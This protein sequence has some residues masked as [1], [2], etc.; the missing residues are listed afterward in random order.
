MAF[1]LCYLCVLCV[2]VVP[3]LTAYYHRGTENTEKAQRK[4]QSSSRQFETQSRGEHK[5]TE[6]RLTKS[7]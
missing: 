7:Y 1:S 5:D 2:S 6:K 3:L 4:L